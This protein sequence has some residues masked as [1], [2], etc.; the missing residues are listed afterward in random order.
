MIFELLWTMA[1]ERGQPPWLWVILFFVIGFFA[2][3]ALWVFFDPKTE[4]PPNAEDVAGRHMDYGPWF[5]K[6]AGIM[7]NEG[8][9]KVPVSEL[10]DCVGIDMQNVNK[11]SVPM[12]TN[13]QRAMVGLG[14]DR[15]TKTL[16]K[17]GTTQRCYVRGDAA[18][19]MWWS[20]YP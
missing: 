17:A 7:P 9:I 15:E 6:L 10:W 19:A 3:L 16:R 20:R 4:E 8:D 1:E 12:R 18:T 14:F 5:E 13:M 11:L 2:H